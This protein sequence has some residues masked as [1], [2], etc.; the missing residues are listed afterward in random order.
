MRRCYEHATYI[1]LPRPRLFIYGFKCR[2]A[3]WCGDYWRFII[4][5]HDFK[6]I[7]LYFYISMTL[8]WWQ[9]CRFDFWW[10]YRPAR[11]FNA[12]TSLAICASLHTN[13]NRYLHWREGI[14]H[15]TQHLSK[16]RRCARLEIGR[17]ARFIRTMRWGHDSYFLFSRLLRWRISFKC[18]DYFLTTQYLFTI[19]AGAHT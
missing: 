9:K 19:S 11:S 18:Y 13:Y 16:F 2:H 15:M 7:Y 4:S 10:A 12:T 8:H 6:Y 17:R 5:A 14:C 1:L 3:H